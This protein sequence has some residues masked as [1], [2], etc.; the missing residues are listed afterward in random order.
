MVIDHFIFMT[1]T[2]SEIAVGSS[3]TVTGF[4][5]FDSH[6]QRIMAL[7]LVEGVPI[8]LIRRAPA[9]DPIELDVLGDRLSI[10]GEDAKRILVKAQ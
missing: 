10:R 7:G 3:A 6:V 2:L 9:G 1:K 4:V 5:E 8:K